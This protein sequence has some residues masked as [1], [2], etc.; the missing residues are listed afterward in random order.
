MNTTTRYNT[1]IQEEKGKILSTVVV[2]NAD[3]TPHDVVSVKKAM[4]MLARQ[5]VVVEEA[6][7]GKT[8]GPF[9]LP[10]IIRLVRYVYIKYKNRRNKPK[11][12]RVGVLKRDNHTCGYCGKYGN[13]IDHIKPVSQGGLSTWENVITACG[14][15]KGCN[16][17]K[18]NRTPEEANMPLLFKPKVP[19]FFDL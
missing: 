2:I 10:K 11:Y 5:V 1:H 17:K 19:T 14:G 6:E 18:R 13:T 12:S 15:P 7:S 4:Q 9:P 16:G 3:Y 8:F